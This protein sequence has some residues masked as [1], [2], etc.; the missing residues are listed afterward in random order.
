METARNSQRSG[1]SSVNH[2]L[3]LYSRHI[4]CSV[5]KDGVAQLQNFMG[6]RCGVNAYSWGNCYHRLREGERRGRRSRSRCQVIIVSSP[7]CV[8]YVCRCV[9]MALLQYY[10]TANNVAMS[11]LSLVRRYRGQHP[12]DSNSS[13]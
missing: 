11:T 7:C 13:P 5:H 2:P 10:I 4:R 3:P 8:N 12:Q 6:K 1:Y 9:C